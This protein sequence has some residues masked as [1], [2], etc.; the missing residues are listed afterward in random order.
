M[1]WIEFLKT[2]GALA[3]VGVFS[4]IMAGVGSRLFRWARVGIDDPAEYLLCAIATGVILFELV[5]FFLATAEVLLPGLW[6]LLCACGLIAFLEMAALR[7]RTRELWVRARGQSG[8]AKIVC[9]LFLL[10]L[11]FEGVTAM[12][13]LTGSDAMHYHFAVPCLVLSQGWHAIFFLTHSF[14]TGQ[15]H[16]LILAGLGLGSERLALG[17]LFLGGALAALAAACLARR[18]MP[19]AGAWLMALTFVLTPVV[20]WQMSTAGTPDLWMALYAVLSLLMIARF[21]QSHAKVY[22]WLAGAFAGAIAGTKYTGCVIAGSLALALLLESRS[23]RALGMFFAAALS[24]GIWP[25]ARNTVW[26]GDPVFPFFAARLQPGNYNAY[27]MAAILA[28]TGGSGKWHV[29]DLLRFPLFAAIDE[30][31][32]GLWQFLGPICLVFAPLLFFAWRKTVLW[33][34]CL[35][36][37]TVSTVG[38]GL[39]SGMMR[40]AVPVYPLTLAAVMAGLWSIPMREWKLVRT[41]AWATLVGFLVLGAGGLLMYGRAA[42]MAAIGAQ[43]REDYLAAHAPDFSKARF[44]NDALRGRPGK[45]LIF[46]QHVYHLQVPYVYGNPDGSWAVD[47]DK[48]Q[49]NAQWEEFFQKEQIRWVVKAPQYPQALAESLRKLEAEGLLVTIASGEVEDFSGNRIRG[50]RERISVEILQVQEG[51]EVKE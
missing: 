20:F 11:A 7:E 6:F 15:G 45:A 17:F 48:L 2:L 3:G 10:T 44:V 49:S 43:S 21:V 31:N 4:L 13:P 19:S 42:A 5:C 37:W 38:I 23:M 24:A 36:V 41:L 12:A 26:T 33:R 50:V 27:A 40:F 51:I 35:V 14:L 28:D 8:A 30:K 16:L 18:W 25:Y 34:G 9:G 22:C 1:I 39:T 32:I 29:L 46:F 47:P